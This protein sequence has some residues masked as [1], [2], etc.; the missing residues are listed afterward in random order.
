MY[1]SVQITVDRYGHL[2]P[3]DR[4]AAAGCLEQSLA[5]SKNQAEQAGTP[6]NT[7]TNVEGRPRG[8]A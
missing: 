4:R 2:F 7:A 5:S 1:A 8:S 6:E 3:D